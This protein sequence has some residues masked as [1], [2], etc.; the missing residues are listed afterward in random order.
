MVS[1]HLSPKYPNPSP[2]PIFTTCEVQSCAIA[3]KFM[4]GD[5]KRGAT[6]AVVYT[7]L[8]NFIH[9]HVHTGTVLYCYMFFRALLWRLLA[10]PKLSSKTKKPTPGVPFFKQDENLFVDLKDIIHTFGIMLIFFTIV[11]KFINPIH[12]KKGYNFSRLLTVMSLT[13]L[14]LAGNN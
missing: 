13:K 4:F 11:G 14:S 1:Q 5:R 6:N 10:N 8:A 7:L 3:L 9:I 2:L 12:C